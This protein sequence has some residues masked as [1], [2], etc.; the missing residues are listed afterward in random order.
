MSD[1]LSHSI[2]KRNILTSL[3][4]EMF[5]FLLKNKLTKGVLL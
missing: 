2:V 1:S 5:R 4:G 3:R